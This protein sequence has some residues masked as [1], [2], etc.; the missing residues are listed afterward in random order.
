M[1]VA[2]GFLVEEQMISSKAGVVDVGGWGCFLHL[3]RLGPD[4]TRAGAW[5]LLVCTLWD[6]KPRVGRFVAGDCT[7]QVGPAGTGRHSLAGPE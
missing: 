1:V 2:E 5:L 4:Y 3:S 7:Q 6:G